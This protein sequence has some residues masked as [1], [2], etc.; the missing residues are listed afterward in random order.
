MKVGWRGRRRDVGCDAKKAH[1]SGRGVVGD[2]VSGGGNAEGTPFVCV[3]GT[4][5]KS[6]RRNATLP[7][8][9]DF[10][11]IALRDVGNF[12]RCSGRE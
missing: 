4:A 8:N 2:S 3:V 7:G 12:K 11:P 1:R 5:E 6:K 9:D 10:P